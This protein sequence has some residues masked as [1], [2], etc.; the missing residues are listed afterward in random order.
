MDPRRT[1]VAALLG[2]ALAPGLAAAQ[3]VTNTGTGISYSTLAA[4]I[5]DAAPGDTLELSGALA[6]NVVVDRDLTLVGLPGAALTAAAGNLIELTAGVDLAIDGLLLDGT[7]PTRGILAPGDN[8]LVVENSTFSTGSPLAG[9]D[10]GGIHATEPRQVLVRNVVFAGAGEVWGDRGGAVFATATGGA[11][12]VFEDVRFEQVRST[13][14]GG[15]IWASNVALSCTRCTF[16]RT[17]G[18]F[19]GAIYAAFATLQVEQ[20]LFCGTHGSLGGGVF[21]SADTTIRTSLFVEGTGSANGTALYAN[22]GDWSF[23]NNHVL[24]MGSPSAAHISSLATSAAVTNNLFLENAGTALSVPAGAVVTYNW[25]WGNATDANAALDATNSA[26]VA[27]PLLVDWQRDGDC[28]ND[29]LWPT[30]IL[31]P[32][33]D[34]GDPALLD[35]DGSRSDIGAFGGPAADPYY[36]TDHDGDGVPFLDDCDDGHAGVYPG[37]VEICDNLDNNCDGLVDVGANDPDNFHQDCDLDG[38]GERSTS[39][40]QCFMPSTPPLCGGVWMSRK[41]DGF[42][43]SSDCDDTD[44]DTHVGAPERCA[45]GDQNC[46]GDDDLY[47]IDALAWVPD[48]DADLFGDASAAPT[49]SCQAGAGLGYLTD[50]SDCDDADPAVN[51]AAPDVPDG[52]DNDC[53]GVVDGAPPACSN[54]LDDDQDGYTDYPADPGCFS[55]TL[56]RENPQCQD[57]IDDDGDGLVD[58]DGGQSMHG[59]CSGGVCP[60]GVSDPDGD[61]VADPD[62]Q[63]VGKPALNKETGGCGIGFELALVLPLLRALRRLRRASPAEGS[64]PA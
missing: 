57:G 40:V 2:V 31:S 25:F 49:L 52:I 60:A 13:D 51:P 36:T 12:V 1:L 37:A 47:A 26:G 3:S 8:T 35:P 27:D 11:P 30:P 14:Q 44:P 38:Q 22:G 21:S 43:A 48:A 58:F 7:G 10:G 6:E 41:L 46:D 29:A 42:V 24:G 23:V 53:D 33:L 34:A 56:L 16:D 19:G 55:P 32:L 62:P 5:A 61:G 9:A 63:C 20:S 17:R 59:A 39:Y 4:A 18:S 45:Y 64:Q 54:G 50:A 15:A 28:T